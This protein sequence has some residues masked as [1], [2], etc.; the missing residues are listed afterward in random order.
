MDRYF[1]FR[2]IGGTFFAIFRRTGLTGSEDDPL[3]NSFGLFHSGKKILNEITIEQK[4]IVSTFCENVK[5]IVSVHW[6]YKVNY[7]E[8]RTVPLSSC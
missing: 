2:W 3:K 8:L 7:N 4:C 5:N 1:Y 6:N